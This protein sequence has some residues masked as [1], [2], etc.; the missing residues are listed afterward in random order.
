[1]SLEN[2]RVEGKG[3]VH[4]AGQKTSFKL[5]KREGSQFIFS[6]KFY[7]MGWNRTDEQCVSEAIRQ[8]NKEE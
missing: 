7:A 8:M 5:F 2:Y 1:M 6:G 3:N 4:Q